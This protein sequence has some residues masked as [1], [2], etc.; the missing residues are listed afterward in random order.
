MQRDMENYNTELHIL[1]RKL[2]S[3]VE[4]NNVLRHSL[5]RWRNEA[6][7]Y[8]NANNNKYLYDDIGS[9]GYNP[10]PTSAPVR[11]YTYDYDDQ[12]YAP[13]AQAPMPSVDNSNDPFEFLNAIDNMKA[14]NTNTAPR[15]S[16]VRARPKTE[17]PP[18]PAAAQQPQPRNTVNAAP[19][20]DKRDAD[21]NIFTGENKRT[22]NK[23]LTAKDI[24]TQAMG[25]RYVIMMV[26]VMHRVPFALD[27]DVRNTSLE[28]EIVDV[29]SKRNRLLDEINKLPEH[30]RTAQ[31]LRQRQEMEQN[32][33]VCV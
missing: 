11:Q 9:G 8:S 33:A 15:E 10:K 5:E 30:S 18:P 12:S 4:E 27:S 7:S 28:D 17:P 14:K 31:A 21:F 19:D 1:K 32:L 23:D 22:N 24:K 13:P 20:K 29:V 16:P 26:M 3:I 6:A 2:T 25:N